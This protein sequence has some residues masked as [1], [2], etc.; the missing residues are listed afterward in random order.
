MVSAV[1]SAGDVV[2][3]GGGEP[4]PAD[5]G[6]R[7]ARRRLDAARAAGERRGQDGRGKGLRHDR[8]AGHGATLLVPPGRPP[9]ASS[10]LRW[11]SSAVFN[12]AFIGSGSIAG[13]HAGGCDKD[14]VNIAAAVDTNAA[15][16]R[17]SRQTTGGFVQFGRRVLRGRRRRPQDR[18]GRAVHPPLGEA[19]RP[20][21]D[22]VERGMHTLIEKPL[23]TTPDGAQRR[24]PR[25]RDA[26]SPACGSA[27][28]IAIASRRRPDHA[29]ADRTPATGRQT[30]PLRE[31]LRLPPSADGGEVVQRPG[32]ERRGGADGRGVPQHRP[33]PL[34][35]RPVRAARGG[36]RS[37]VV[38]SR[39]VGGDGPA[40]L[41][42]R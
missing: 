26:R 12:I 37:S 30:D 19:R 13:T 33:L 27:S 8:S 36:A 11:E 14:Q 21:K 17:S 38:G 22:L 9:G 28:A 6:G 10:K 40:P 42:R 5:L 25:L 3:G 32:R 16:P 35:R 2:V 20:R 31:H 15:P 41:R 7:R 29:R 34:P 24:S 4:R 23:A 39:R 18:R 1:F